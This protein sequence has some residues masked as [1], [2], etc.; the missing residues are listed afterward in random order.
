MQF[1]A[2]NVTKV[3]LESTPATMVHNIAIKLAP[4]TWAITLY[5]NFSAASFRI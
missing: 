2:R 1:L 4:C 3:E 5:T